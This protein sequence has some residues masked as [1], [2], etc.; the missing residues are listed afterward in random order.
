MI[1]FSFKNYGLF[2]YHSD[3]RLFNY[4]NYPFLLMNILSARMLNGATA[5]Y[6]W[7]WQSK[8]ASLNQRLEEMLYQ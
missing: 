1:A 8:I 7:H 6:T 5:K 2:L 3:L 4:S